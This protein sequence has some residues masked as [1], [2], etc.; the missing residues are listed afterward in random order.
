MFDARQIHKEVTQ[1]VSEASKV[2][3]NSLITFT[4]L[5]PRP[6]DFPR[7]RARCESYSRTYQLAVQGLSASGKGNCSYM[8]AAQEFLTQ[9]G[10]ILN[11]DTNFEGELCLKPGFAYS[12]L[13][14]CAI[15]DSFRPEPERCKIVTLTGNGFSFLAL[16]G[17]VR[18]VLALAC[19]LVVC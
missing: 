9:D 10:R 4:G 15:W 3:P 2:S 13:L 6:M 8:L 17:V 11:P 5:V 7:S 12:E 16:G 14:G 19:R 18:A 1:F